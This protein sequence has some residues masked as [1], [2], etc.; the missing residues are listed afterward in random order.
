MLSET[1][2]V[3]KHH[4]SRLHLTYPVDAEYLQTFCTLVAHMESDHNP[5]ARSFISTAKGLYQFIDGS[6]TPAINR[7]R[8]A[9]GDAP[10]LAA[11]ETRRD[12]TRFGADK[13]TALFLGNILEMKG[14]DPFIMNIA[15]TGSRGAMKQLYAEKHHTNPDEATLARMEKVFV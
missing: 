5:K 4:L 6:L 1:Q 14:T 2:K 3:L 11:L 7:T 10:W 13:Q 15:L 8:K 9:L 12:I